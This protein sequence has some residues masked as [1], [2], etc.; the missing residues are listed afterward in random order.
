MLIS[1]K[2]LSVVDCSLAALVGFSGIAI[3]LMTVERGVWIDEFIK[4]AWTTPD[5]SLREFLHLMIA[6]DLHP[7]L[8][9]GMVYLLQ[10]AGVTDVALLRSLNLLGLPLVI[11]AI[12]YGFRDK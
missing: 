6:R 1:K 5:T 3:A 7:I 10:A 9:Y 4:I 11:F 12:A 2:T 8:H